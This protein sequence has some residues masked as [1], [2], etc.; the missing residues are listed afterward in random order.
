MGSQPTEAPVLPKGPGGAGHSPPLR[1]R[2]GS[3]LG[4]EMGSHHSP[5]ED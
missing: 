5:S 4:W 1:W 3:D 2:S